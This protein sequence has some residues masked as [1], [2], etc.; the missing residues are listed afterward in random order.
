MPP[1]KFENVHPRVLAA[2]EEGLSLTDAC[3]RVGIPYNTVCNW[4]SDGRHNQEGRHGAFAAAVD[5]ARSNGRLDH[6]EGYEPGPVEREVCH[7]IAGRALDQH[8][9]IA[10]AQARALAQQV[11]RL[12][13][14]RTAAAA[15]GMTAASRRLDDL[16]AGLR[17]QP[18]DALTQLGR[19]RA[20]RLASFGNG[21][22]PDAAL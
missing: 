5:A 22:V 16:V 18:E 1:S 17:V 2:V 21:K 4:L 6:D 3:A 9:H 13:T 10:A 15:L 14:S 11:D 19:E 8:G 7:L 20:A 12:A